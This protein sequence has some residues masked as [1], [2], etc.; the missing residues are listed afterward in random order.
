MAT[1][2]NKPCALAGARVLI[3]RPEPEAS[4]LATAFEAAGASARVLPAIERVPLPE[5]PEARQ[6]ILDLDLYQ[7]VIAVSPYAAR[8]L[9][10]RIDTWWPQLPVGIQ[11]YGVG[12]GTAAVMAG[13]GLAPEHP[14]T[15]FT[16]EA[17][18][19]HPS[20]QALA[21]DK[22][23]LARGEQGRELLRETLEQRGA[24]VTVLPLYRRQRPS[25]PSELV[26]ASLDDFKPDVVIALSGET[27]NNFIALSENSSHNCHDSL[28]LVPVDRVARQ[29]REAGFAR[30]V[31]ATGMAD[32]EI[33]DRVIHCYPHLQ[34]GITCHPERPD[35][36]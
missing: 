12:A 29:A 31:S 27:L 18:L 20:L 28:L 24:R 6:V 7:H 33:V 26:E 1:P 10:E 9:L 25:P 3:C 16:S 21:N 13:A 19:Q 4:R 2:R 23:L 30:V 11:W 8:Q 35:R 15:G 32:E 22:V 14:A 36:Q 34:N 17:L 5:T